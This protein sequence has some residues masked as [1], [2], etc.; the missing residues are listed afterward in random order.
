MKPFFSAAAF[1]LFFIFC[2]ES[3]AQIQPALIF[4][5]NMV[6][7]R[8]IKIPVWGTAAPGEVVTVLFGEKTVSGAT[9]KSGKWK[10]F[11]PE[12]NSVRASRYF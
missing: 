8:D 7:Q 9:D 1:S 12:N 2:S 4:S 6:L 10:I 3:F 11:L 5:D